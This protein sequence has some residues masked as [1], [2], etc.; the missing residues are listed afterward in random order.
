MEGVKG[1]DRPAE[2]DEIVALLVEAHNT[3]GDCICE[4]GISNRT[5]KL[6]ERIRAVLDREDS[7]YEA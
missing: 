7:V 5:E 4:T 1:E 3:L 2:R 6:L